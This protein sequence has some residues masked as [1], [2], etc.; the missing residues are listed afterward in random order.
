MPDQSIGGV[1]LPSGTDY[2]AGGS[3]RPSST[4]AGFSRTLRRKVHEHFG[5]VAELA[6]GP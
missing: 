2:D 4:R 5:P 6:T 1:T 3:L